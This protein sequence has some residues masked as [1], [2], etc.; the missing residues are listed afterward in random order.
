MSHAYKKQNTWEKS[1][2]KLNTGYRKWFIG[3]EKHRKRIGIMVDKELK[4]NVADIKRLG[5]RIIRINLVS[6]KRS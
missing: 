1:L 2:E 6:K 4:K 3:K 5:D